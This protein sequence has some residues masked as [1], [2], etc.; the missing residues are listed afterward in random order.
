MR[1]PRC[2]LTARASTSSAMRTKPPGIT[3]QPSPTLARNRRS[4]NGRGCEPAV[5][6]HRR[7]RQRHRLLRDVVDAAVAR[8]P[9]RR[10]S[11]CGG[12]ERRRRARPSLERSSAMRSRRPARSPCRRAC[13]ASRRARSA[14][15]S[16]QVATF[17]RRGR[18]PSTCGASAGRKASMARASTRP[19]PSALAITTLPSRTACTRPGTPSRE[20]GVELERIGEVGI[21]PAQ[22]HFGALQAGDGADEDAVVAHASGLRPRPA[23]SRDSAR[24]RRARNR[25]RSAA[26]A[27]AGRRAR[28]PAG[29]APTSSA[30]NA[31][32][33]GAS[34]STRSCA[35]DVGHG[36]RQREPVLE[37]VAGAR[38]RLRAVAE[39]PPAAVRAAADDRP[40]RS[41]DARRPAAR[42]R[43][44]GAGI[45][46]CR[47]PAPPAAGRRA[48]RLRR[49]VGVGEHALRAARRAGSGRPRAASIRPA[50]MSS[51][52]WL[53]GQGR[54]APAGSS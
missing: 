24:D 14:L 7:G 42:R 15:P 11:R 5:A 31:W 49:A 9:G 13:R 28:R 25:S 32:K 20:R 35:I 12:I 54:S 8:S 29:R 16:H 37:R 40:R 30:W 52:T 19:A 3:C 18:S 21:E 26:R 53:S 47:R 6:P 41:A 45:P 50:S 34:R 51:G 36:A 39:H 46:D 44:A 17:G 2:R 27:S 10:A 1:A 43:P 23:G 4:V 22:Q 38:R 33:N 48:T